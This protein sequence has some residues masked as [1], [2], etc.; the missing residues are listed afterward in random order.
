MLEY[1]ALI[2]LSEKPIKKRKLTCN[3]DAFVTHLAI[4]EIEDTAVLTSVSTF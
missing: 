1:E 4:R 3:L 2:K